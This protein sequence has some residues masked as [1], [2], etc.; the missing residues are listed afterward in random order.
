MLH[1]AVGKLLTAYIISHQGFL[2]FYT[3]IIH[4]FSFFSYAEFFLYSF[5][6]AKWNSPEGG[7]FFPAQKYAQYF[8]C[9]V[10]F[11]SLLNI[12]LYNVTES[13][14]CCSLP[15]EIEHLKKK[16]YPLRREKKIFE[17]HSQALKLRRQ[18]DA[19]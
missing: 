9:S 14:V 15:Y 12:A 17:F 6:V 18:N 1:I 8:V 19:V 3:F 16:F 10:F 11:F 4:C 5:F 2:A 13:L 7:I